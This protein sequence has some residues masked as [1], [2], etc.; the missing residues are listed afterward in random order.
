M[1]DA[2]AGQNL[3]VVAADCALVTDRQCDDDS[4]VRSAGQGL[5]QVRADLFA[6]S[7]DHAFDRPDEGSGQH[8]RGVAVA[9]ANVT[10]GADPALQEPGFVV[11]A[12][13][14][15]AAMR[16]A[17]PR[18]QAP[19]LA[20][21]HRR[22]I[23]R[24]IVIPGQLQVFRHVRA[25]SVG[26]LHHELEPGAAL[27]RLRQRGYYAREGDVAPFP[28]ERQGV[29]EPPGG[30]RTGPGEAEQQGRERRASG[31][32]LRA[33]SGGTMNAAP[34]A[35]AIAHSASPDGRADCICTSAVPRANP[36]RARRMDEFYGA[37]A[38]EA[39]LYVYSCLYNCIQKRIAKQ[40]RCR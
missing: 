15:G 27:E 10:G 4:A 19:A 40:N 31:R 18:I 16:A 28:L 7:V 22:R 9:A 12:L 24:A 14:V 1:T 32:Q 34:P 21:V 2:G 3:P 25:G 8:R 30:K 6:H 38:P 11:E 33:S 36:T 20:G 37:A 29:G 23:G 17:Q 13:R 26:V 5:L 39:R 35:A